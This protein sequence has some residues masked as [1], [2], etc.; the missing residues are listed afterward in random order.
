MG[1]LFSVIVIPIFAVGHIYCSYK[2]PEF[3]GMSLWQRIRKLCQPTDKWGPSIGVNERRITGDNTP[4]EKQTDNGYNSNYGDK[5]NSQFDNPAFQ[6]NQ[7][8]TR[9]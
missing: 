6:D 1:A 9:F 8:N 3:D 4:Q 7:D 5:A 2:K